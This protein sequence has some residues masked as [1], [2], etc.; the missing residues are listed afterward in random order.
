MS[1][2]SPGY[3]PNNLRP[4]SSLALNSE[5]FR[6]M[7]FLFREKVTIFIYKEALNGQQGSLHFK[8]SQNY[9]RTHIQDTALTTGQGS[10]K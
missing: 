6:S 10:D 4:A 3:A 2:P 9:I 1:P 8:K 7:D 5:S